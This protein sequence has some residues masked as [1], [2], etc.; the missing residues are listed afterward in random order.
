MT[1]EYPHSS[2]FPHT[3][4]LDFSFFSLLKFNNSFFNGTHFYSIH[5]LICI[6]F[7]LMKPSLKDFNHYFG[8]NQKKT[9]RILKL[10]YDGPG[11]MYMCC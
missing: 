8:I 6:F 2:S 11:S 3:Q 5:S 10:F 9:P 1:N 7:T 4:L